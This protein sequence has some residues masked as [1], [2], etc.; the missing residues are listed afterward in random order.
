MTDESYES[1]AKEAED[2]ARRAETAA[3]RKSFEDIAKIWRDLAER[4]KR[5]KPNSSPK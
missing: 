4:K 2:L 1:R 5:K 3:E